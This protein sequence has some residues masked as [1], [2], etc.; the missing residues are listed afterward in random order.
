VQLVLLVT[1]EL[2]WVAVMVVVP[3]ATVVASPWLPPALLIVATPVLEEDQA[4]EL[5]TSR[6][7]P[8]V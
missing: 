7:V 5:L 6:L 8:S 4:T 3:V 1:P 2:E